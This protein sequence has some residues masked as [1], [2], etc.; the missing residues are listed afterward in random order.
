MEMD[1]SKL[2]HPDGQFNLEVPK[3]MPMELK[4]RMF[5]AAEA[6]RK[7]WEYENYTPDRSNA[8]LV[9]SPSEHEGGSPL[10][11][12]LSR[13]FLKGA[14]NREIA[15]RQP[16]RDEL[17]GAEADRAK[18][19]A[20]KARST[21]KKS[22]VERVLARP[23]SKGTQAMA[24]AASQARNDLEDD[25]VVAHSDMGTLGSPQAPLDPTDYHTVLGSSDDESSS[26]R[27]EPS[28]GRK[29]REE[30]LRGDLESPIKPAFSET[31]RNTS[32]RSPLRSA[33][34]KRKAWGAGEQL[35]ASLT[36]AAET[37]RSVSSEPRMK[38]RPKTPQ[39][40]TVPDE[41]IALDLD[42]SSGIQNRESRIQDRLYK[43]RSQL[44]ARFLDKEVVIKE[45]LPRDEM[46]V[47]IDYCT[48]ED[49]RKMRDSDAL[50]LLNQ[51]CG[52]IDDPDEDHSP[53]VGISQPERPT[54]ERRAVI[55][56][57]A[58]T[59]SAR[60]SLY[61][62]EGETVHHNTVHGQPP[63]GSVHD[64]A[65][66]VEV[67]Y[68]DREYGDD[69]AG[70]SR[71]LE[72]IR[73]S[74]K[75]YQG[76]P[77]LTNICEISSSYD[78]SSSESGTESGEISSS[79]NESERAPYITGRPSD[80]STLRG[81]GGQRFGVGQRPGAMDQQTIV[82]ATST[83]FQPLIPGLKNPPTE[84]DISRLDELFRKNVHIVWPEKVLQHVSRNGVITSWR[85]CIPPYVRDWLVDRVRL[86]M[87]TTFGGPEMQRDR[88][89][90]FFKHRQ[91]TKRRG[92]V[93]DYKMYADLGKRFDQLRWDRPVSYSNSVWR[94]LQ[95]LFP[96]TTEE[97]HLTE[98]AAAL[99]GA[100]FRVP[101]KPCTI[102]ADVG[103]MYALVVAAVQRT[104]RNETDT[105]DN[106]S[107]KDSQE[108]CAAFFH[109]LTQV[110]QK[111]QGTS[112]ARWCEEAIRDLKDTANP[113]FKEEDFR[114]PD[115]GRAMWPKLSV[116]CAWYQH[117]SLRAFNDI[118]ERGRNLGYQTLSGNQQGSSSGDRPPA[119]DRSDFSNRKARRASERQQYRDNAAK[120]PASSS[121]R[122][123]AEEETTVAATSSTTEHNRSS[124]KVTKCHACGREN[125]GDYGHTRDNCPFITHNPPHPG[126]NKAGNWEN[127]QSY[128]HLQ[129][130][131]APDGKP[132]RTLQFRRHV[133]KQQDGK[134]VLESIDSG[135]AKK[136]AKQKPKVRQFLT[137]LASNKLRQSG[138]L[139]DLTPAFSL[140]CR[141][142]RN[143]IGTCK[144][145]PAMVL[146]DT[147]ATD[148]NFVDRAFVVKNKLPIRVMPGPIRVRS[149]H[150]TS[151]VYEY[152]IVP[153]KLKYCDNILTMVIPCLILD[154]SP[155]DIILG[156]PAITQYDITNKLSEY[157]KEKGEELAR[158]QEKLFPGFTPSEANQ[159]ES[160]NP[161]KGESSQTL[162]SS[163]FAITEYPHPRA[164]VL[165]KHPEATAP[166]SRAPDEVRSQTLMSSADRL[167][168]TY[169]V[170]HRDELLDTAVEPDIDSIPVDDEP[171]DPVAREPENPT[172]EAQPK[173][174]GPPGFRRRLQRLIAKHKHVFATQLPAEPARIK[175]AS[176]KIDAA[177]WRAD[178]RSRQYAR[179]LSHD[180]EIA[181]EEWAKLALQAGI[182]SE[183]PAVPNWSQI[184]LVLKQNK[185][186]YR[187]C[188][189][190]TVLNSFMESAGWPIP[191]IGSI[192]RRIA[193]HKPK[194]FA[195]MDST[196][197]FYQMELEMSCREFLCFTTYLGNFVWNRA[198]MG[199]K[200]VPA[201]FQRAMCVEVFPDL[202][203]KIMEVYI[204]DFIVWAQSEDELITR[205]DAVFTRLSEKNLKLNPKKCRFG[206]TEVEYCGHVINDQGTT[207]SAERISEV[208]DFAV[209]QNHGELK[210]FLGMAGYMREHIPHYVEM[211]EPLQNIVR[212]YTKRTRKQ[213]IV[214]TPELLQCFADFKESIAKVYTLFHRNDEAPLRLYTDASSYGIGAYLCQVVSLQDGTLQEQPLGF[215]SKSLSDT[216]RRWSVY[217]KEGYAIFYAC[218]K[219]EHFLRGN[220][221]FLFT[222]HKNLTFLN[223]PPSEKV[224]RWRLAIQEFD[225][226][227][228]YIKGETNNVADAMSR[229]V[230]STKDAVRALN[231]GSVRNTMLHHLQSADTFDLLESVPATWY[232]ILERE[233]R[234]QYFV[235]EK[236][237]SHFL[238]LLD[239]TP[240]DIDL[241]HVGW[242]SKNKPTVQQS[243]VSG[244][245]RP[246]T[247]LKRCTAPTQVQHKKLEEPS[248][249]QSRSTDRFVYTLLCSNETTHEV[250]QNESTPLA[251]EIEDLIASCHNTN[252]GH[253]GVDRTLNLL[254]ELRKKDSSKESIFAN[255]SYKRADVRRFVKA[256]PICQKIKQH[257]LLK[258]TPHFTTSTYGIFDNISIDTIYM[259]ESARGNKYLIVMI[260]SFSR[261]LD[262]YPVSEL[263]SKTALT[264][265]IQ[266]MSNF[267]IPS[268]LCCDNGSQFQG[269]FQELIDLLAINGYKTHPY[270]H[271]ENSIVERANKEILTSLRALVLERRL[272]DDWDILCH[273]AKRIINSRIH[274]AIG[275][276]PADLVFAG[277]IDL[278]RGSLFPYP[279]PESFS[280]TDYMATLMQHQEKML[281][282]AIKLQKEHDA[283]RLKDNKHALKTV[284][285]ISSYVL[286]KP[287]VE[288]ENK[289]APRW[290]GPYLITQRFERREGDV[291]RCLHLS[292]NKEFDFR[293][294]RLDPYY[295]YD[296]RTLH[297][298][299]MLD[300]EQYEVEKV[301]QHRFNSQGT[302]TASN[303]QLEIKWLGY[304]KPEWQPYSGNGLNEVGVVH[305]YLRQHKLVRLIPQKFR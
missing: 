205:L 44:P 63:Q 210:S 211:A 146:I 262:V 91:P 114:L 186:E 213:A 125:D 141:S 194:Y 259:P 222:D 200:T 145:Q 69:S 131:L 219:W 78:T 149:V 127:S 232:D 272:K 279:T 93:A 215:I 58:P 170:Q 11:N 248:L 118:V 242:A 67:D 147:G 168:S 144:E 274:S 77:H 300:D 98:R 217:E 249:S 275:I 148:F 197:G 288:P 224:M 223:R 294:D 161:S 281:N 265:L 59:N 27:R 261:Y 139:I 230:P 6:A 14:E 220:H 214:W 112:E 36:V 94:V 65:E 35:A 64:Y 206:M 276:A 43:A 187:F 253:G 260:D 56:S 105:L 8:D 12:N 123:E 212:H 163:A 129:K 277:R 162:M 50:K 107:V 286:V 156:L 109:R 74:N 83:M 85:Q 115:G 238:G 283:L 291:Y 184:L 172:E 174:Y 108:S 49:L 55:S 130:V 181:L 189:D 61:R 24:A 182:I 192:L 236:N 176:F 32:G 19:Q 5:D 16:R 117:F 142:D 103:Y 195:T 221:F 267:G 101:L 47:R 167:P 165:P 171:P 234:P 153:V 173:L 183:A 99:K 45:D 208:A 289:L 134:F 29:R 190:Y 102:R 299:A 70:Q 257:Q 258:Y 235:Q 255:W 209:P 293:V 7:V 62:V 135:P 282:T 128:K 207:F 196:Q 180:K 150:S 90:E 233:N 157:F 164:P 169:T 302:Q 37:T 76:T 113:F 247:P 68:D 285:P 203:H 52:D 175:P 26:E 152:S 110:T 204:D 54:A 245:R 231:E 218:K 280:G 292:T 202:V 256:C 136:D 84:Q 124:N 126:A 250:V 42:T 106:I 92:G 122:T 263:S 116:L 3:A 111:E 100:I 104:A 228:A 239:G 28:S 303:L 38:K 155:R 201:L 151:I 251:K 295:T 158:L 34:G 88:W 23:D 241:Y 60:S 86:A 287:E 178:K 133:V 254:D 80:F 154:N 240:Q 304:E 166:S 89:P 40:D 269:L 185:K 9:S 268:H 271:Q 79:D 244:R 97:S 177:G 33:K 137:S 13:R 305:E 48:L 4:Q 179:P 21:A 226:S 66:E 216:E 296:E 96:S 143:I 1:H 243:V 31:L 229:C 72:G 46:R 284:F 119:K 237:I 159:D 82:V 138:R 278:Q 160:D 191:H 298:T 273:V 53:V 301:L 198:P 71:S 225:F 193:S 22:R 75:L 10:A 188:V 270:S 39:S 18:D 25:V 2:Y 290:L 95:R 15:V 30:L 51:V 264:C 227:V 199:P 121:S 17:L 87:R 73:Q 246:S 41:V 132:Y 20:A 252:V 297:D 57:S 140:L 120:K 266:F 81:H